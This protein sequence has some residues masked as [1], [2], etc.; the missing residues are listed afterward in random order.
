[1]KNQGRPLLHLYMHIGRL[2]E[3]ELRRELSVVGVHHGQARVLVKLHRHGPLS[4]ADIARVLSIKPATVTNMLTRMEQASLIQRKPHPQHGR[5]NMTSL[6]KAGVVAA[7]EVLK[8]WEKVE[9]TLLK[10][11]DES[12]IEAVRPA[13]EQVLKNLGGQ[14]PKHRSTRK[15][16]K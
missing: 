6:L 7:H 3:E 1:M 14:L 2:L 15:D 13:L 11:F 10:E 16:K 12:E 4:Q 8:V 9:E 5:K